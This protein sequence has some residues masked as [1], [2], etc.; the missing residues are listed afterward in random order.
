MVREVLLEELPFDQRLK[1]MRE[2]VVQRPGE[3]MTQG[4]GAAPA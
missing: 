2:G 4:E 1:E 3:R